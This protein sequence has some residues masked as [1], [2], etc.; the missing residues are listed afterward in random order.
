MITYTRAAPGILVTG[1][2]TFAIRKFK[3]RGLGTRFSRTLCNFT[4]NL[5]GS[6][7]DSLELRDRTTDMDAVLGYAPRKIFRF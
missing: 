5:H 4:L 6:N 1:V 3:S 2:Q 7:I